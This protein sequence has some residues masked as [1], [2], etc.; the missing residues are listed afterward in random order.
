MTHS[1]KAL[2]LKDKVVS[3]TNQ[4]LFLSYKY[5]FT[6]L[7]KQNVYLLVGVTAACWPQVLAWLGSKTWII[8][9]HR[10]MLAMFSHQQVL[11]PTF[12]NQPSQLHQPRMNMKCSF[13]DNISVPPLL[14]AL[15]CKIFMGRGSL[16]V[17]TMIFHEMLSLLIYCNIWL[18]TYQAKIFENI[19]KY[20][21]QLCRA[22]QQEWLQ[23]I[24]IGLIGCV[25]IFSCNKF[26]V[27]AHQ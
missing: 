3:N 24:V 17:P 27:F 14:N 12:I 20:L 18:C 16:W 10:L 7:V 25:A 23:L 13:I 9:Q 1:L 26:F 4:F 22:A 11:T 8:G 19:W 6:K 15:H 2:Q 21:K 5:I